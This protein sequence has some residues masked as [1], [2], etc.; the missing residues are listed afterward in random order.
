M[1]GPHQDKGEQQ[2]GGDNPECRY[3]G[4]GKHQGVFEHGMAHDEV[5][6]HG[7]GILAAYDSFLFEFHHYG[8]TVADAKDVAY[9]P[10]VGRPTRKTEQGHEWREEVGERCEQP[11]GFDG[12][13]QH[14]QSINDGEEHDGHFELREGPCG[15]YLQQGAVGSGGREGQG[16]DSMHRQRRQGCG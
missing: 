4:G 7:V 2:A 14:H 6:V 5:V 16:S 12:F 3:A 15:Q 13:L 1:P 8:C 10:H 9:E 11:I